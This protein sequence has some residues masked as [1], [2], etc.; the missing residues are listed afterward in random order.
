MWLATYKPYGLEVVEHRY[1]AIR[2][3]LESLAERLGGYLDGTIDDIPELMDERLRFNDA[4]LPDM[5]FDRQRVATAS[6][7]K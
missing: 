6:C 2:T 3:R 1:G 5:W 7:I 4:A